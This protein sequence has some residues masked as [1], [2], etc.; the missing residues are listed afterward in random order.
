[1]LMVRLRY[2]FFLMLIFSS[3]QIFSQEEK[4]LDDIQQSKKTPISLSFGADF[5]S[6]Y[7]WRGSD[8]GNSPA[9]QPNLNFSAGGFSIGAWGSYG[10]AHHSVQINDST[11]VDAGNYAEFDLYISYTYKWFTLMVF[12]FFV[13]NPIDPNYKVNYFNYKNETTGHGLEVSLTF[14]GPEK[15]PLQVM[16]G[17]LVYGDDKD[18]DSTGTYG[19]GNRNNYS[20][21]IE[22]S[23]R[24]NV[25]GI[26][27]KPFIGGIPF[28]S[29]WYGNHGG[30]VNLGLT[31]KKEI[32]VTK[33]FT[34]PVQAS[35]ITNPQAQSIFFV[36]GFSL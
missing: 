32:P 20:T 21:Y 3:I 1:M 36:F 7:I 8:Y 28:G 29:S 30:I 18:Q 13:P 26:E 34:I 15:F 16:V 22:A 33:V 24:F 10:F 25:L 17:T 4:A 6:R 5:M 19:Y 27:L 35:L 12:D 11:M 2:L 31:V 14:N 9:I 23:Y